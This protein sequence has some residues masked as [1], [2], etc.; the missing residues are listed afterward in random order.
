MRRL[1]KWLKRAGIALLAFIVLLLLVNS[2]LIWITGSRLEARLQALRDA[3]EPLTLKEL[4][5]KPIPP[6]KNAATYLRRAKGD[7]DAVMKELGPIYERIIDDEGNDQRSEADSKAIRAVLD[8]HPTLFP[9]LE[10]AAACESYQSGLDYS[11]DGN[12]FLNGL[13]ANVQHDVREPIKILEE[14]VRLQIADGKQDEAVQNAVAILR[15]SRKVQSEPFV[16]SY[17]VVCFVRA[18]GIDSAN[19]VLR[20]GPISQQARAAL[21]AELQAMNADASFERCLKTER[22]F[23]LEMFRGIVR[24]NVAFPNRAY[25]NDEQCHHIDMIGAFL[26]LISKPY[27]EARPEFEKFLKGNKSS[28]RHIVASLNGPALQKVHEAH[29]RTLAHV[30]CLRVL[31]ALQEKAPMADAGTV[32]LADL[33]V[34]ADA[35]GDPYNGL[36]LLVRK[37]GG[38]WIVYCVGTNLIDDGGSLDDKKDVGV[39]PI[40]AKK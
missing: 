28:W 18:I 25:F 2:I 23:G 15:I 14:K 19:R 4:E 27:A 32:K 13:L 1:W 11:T 3:G 26:P 40:A 7:L 34:P 8:S 37:S 30:R 5:P 20:S 12:V 6:D 24:D 9:L 33:G 10:Q 21:D 22:A 36:P 16:I 31:N 29:L 35:T 17:L 39:G 38:D